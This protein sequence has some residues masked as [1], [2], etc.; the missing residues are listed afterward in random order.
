M[1]LNRVNRKKIKMVLD[2]VGTV[3]GRSYQ[4]SNKIR[5]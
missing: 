1:E 4:V 2:K 3:L 5:P